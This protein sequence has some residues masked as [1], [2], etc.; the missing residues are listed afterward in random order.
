MQTQTSIRRWGASVSPNTWRKQRLGSRKDL[1]WQ[2]GAGVGNTKGILED[3]PSLRRTMCPPRHCSDSTAG[4]RPG[5]LPVLKQF[6]HVVKVTSLMPC[7]GGCSAFYTLAIPHRKGQTFIAG[8][9]KLR[10]FPS[11]SEVSFRGWLLSDT[12]PTHTQ[13]LAPSHRVPRHCRGPSPGAAQSDE[14]SRGGDMP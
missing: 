11:P 2:G 8:A 12:R 13:L 5:R 9:E 10:A 7:S 4:G 6:A 14:H 1:S 3:P